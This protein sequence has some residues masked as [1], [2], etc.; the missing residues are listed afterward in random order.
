MEQNR[1]GKMFAYKHFGIVPDIVSTGKAVSGGYFPLAAVSVTEKFYKGLYENKG[2][3]TPG[4]SWSGNPLG[5]AVQIA[6]YKHLVE[7]CAEMGA[8]LKERIKEISKYIQ[9]WEIYEEKV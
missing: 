7:K 9:L 2:D 8:Y 6:A 4:Y 5:A 3:F 1:K